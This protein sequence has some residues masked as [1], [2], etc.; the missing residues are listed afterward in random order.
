MKKS[1]SSAC[2]PRSTMQSWLFSFVIEHVKGISSQ[3]SSLRVSGQMNLYRPALIQEIA[4][5]GVEPNQG[6]PTRAMQKHR[7]A[8][9]EVFRGYGHPAE[10]PIL[11]SLLPNGPWQTTTGPIPLFV[12]NA[13]VSPK[14][15]CKIVQNSVVTAVAGTMFEGIKPGKWR[16][17]ST[18][19]DRPGL[20][21]SIHGL[22]GPTYLWY[23]RMKG[24]KGPGLEHDEPCDFE[25][26][27]IEGPPPG[28]ESA[29][30]YNA[31][32]TNPGDDGGLSECEDDD[33]T[34]ATGG[35]KK[36]MS[37]A[38]NAKNRRSLM[39]WWQLNPY[40]FLVLMRLLL[41][42]LRV[43]LDSKLYV[44][45]EDWK[46]DQFIKACASLTGG[47]AGG[48]QRAYRITVIASNV[49]ENS[50]LQKYWLL[51]TDSS[52]WQLMPKRSVTV[53]MVSLAFRIGS[54]L[55]CGIKE[56]LITRHRKAPS[57]FSGCFMHRSSPSR[58][59]D[60]PNA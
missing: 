32:E 17:A 1:I 22:G 24:Y 60:F 11:V 2:Y 49:H 41:A 12:G 31:D 10:R 29:G 42:P 21:Q 28:E 25:R 46:G 47:A 9:L 51:L 38:E 14:D 37:P 4:E 13:S 5:R 57:C 8:V 39:H 54:R 30:R 16:G 43:L 33:T 55:Q 19:I 35:Y 26:P 3:A 53:R 20:L 23:M 59:C 6:Y 36:T 45:S 44:A 40:A 27:A 58:F 7:E 15:A 50:C 56:L 18:A 48:E 52:L 34:A